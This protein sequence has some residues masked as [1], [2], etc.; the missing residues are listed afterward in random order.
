M[1]NDNLKV[2]RA[3]FKEYE[4]PILRYVITQNGKPI[5]DIYRW[6]D[7]QSS[8]SYLTGKEYAYSLVK[9]LRF[10]EKRNLHYLAVQDKAVINDYIKH[11]LYGGGQVK[12]MKGKMSLSSVKKH[13][14]VLKSFY[15][16]LEDDRKVESNPVKFGNR[17]RKDKNGNQKAYLQSKFFY[18]QIWDFD[19][20]KSFLKKLNYKQK[21]NHIKWY[22]QEEI[23]IILEHLP[24][25][26]DKV[27]FRISLETGARIGEILGLRI[28]DLDA[29]DGWLQ[30]RRNVN[31][32]NEARAKTN[33]RDLPI[34]DS[35]V[36]DIQSYMSGERANVSL[37]IDS[38][39]L[40]VNY[41][42]EH[43]GKPMKP[44]NFLRILKTASKKAGLS[45]NEIRTHSGRSTRVQ[46]LIEESRV[47][48]KITDTLIME[49]MGW[50]SSESLKYYKK[51]FSVAHKKEIL[52]KVNEKRI[53]KRE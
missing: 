13:I 39:Y 30:I 52:D 53:K 26:R 23:D 21:Q 22:T 8:N 31:I 14:G 7:Y 2:K 33:E 11:L 47:N 50:S 38:D 16:W 45:P 51:A 5:E 37:E 35:L 28:E 10:L 49:E 6:L 19:F 20:D 18:G 43:K 24:T 25:V 48:P 27:I 1:D 4:E 46:Q 9:Y 42:G 29:F 17:K 34:L 40:F 36:E 15:D 41:K 44:R 32:E 3:I 12:K